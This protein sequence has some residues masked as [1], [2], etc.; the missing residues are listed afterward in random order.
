MSDNRI[1]KLENWIL[2]HCYLKTI[3]KELPNTWKKPRHYDYSKEIRIRNLNSSDESI[4]KSAEFDLKTLE[5]YLFK[6][7]ILLNYFNLQLSYKE[8]FWSEY[9]EKF[10]DTREYRSALASLSRTLK[11]LV[12]K[13]LISWWYNDFFRWKG[14]KLTDKGILKTESIL[15]VNNRKTQPTININKKEVF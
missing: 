3:K 9:N 13:D 6:Y 11:N 5:S 10:K 14:Y 1:G 7:D 4:K 8:G 15:N 12:D 2:I